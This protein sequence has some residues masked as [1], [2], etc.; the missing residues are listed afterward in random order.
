MT[1]FKNLYK[2][3]LIERIDSVYPFNFLPLFYCIENPSR[4]THSPTIVTSAMSS[5]DQVKYTGKLQNKNVLVL[6]GSSGIGFAVA[7]AALE[8]GSVVTVSSSNSERVQDAVAKLQSAY[9]SKSG[10]VR[11]HVCDI[12]IQDK[13]EE[14]TIALLDGV[15]KDTGR[16]IDH[17][18]HT[19][20]TPVVQIT[21]R[22]SRND[23]FALQ[24]LQS[25]FQ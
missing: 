24:H 16:K 21:P 13:L 12:S 15:V 2:I 1:I 8:F 20:R 6:G 19:V 17:I 23:A 14:N 11:G 4:K 7:E 3:T 25:V 9:P 10:N 22:P 5:Q 18:V